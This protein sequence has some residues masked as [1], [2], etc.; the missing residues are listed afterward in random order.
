MLEDLQAFH[1]SK[2][3]EGEIIAE[4][5]SKEVKEAITNQ[6]E[7]IQHSLETLYRVYSKELPA[8]IPMSMIGNLN[9]VSSLVR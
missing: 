9:K 6:V 3:D 5:R 4:D 2:V 1:D 8:I 7:L